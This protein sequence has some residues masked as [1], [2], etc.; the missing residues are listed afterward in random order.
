MYSAC[1]C[2]RTSFC[3][4][5]FLR[6][7]TIS[8]QLQIVLDQLVCG[9]TVKLIIFDS[10]NY[11]CKSTERQSLNENTRSYA[12]RHAI[13]HY[14]VIALNS[15]TGFFLSATRLYKEHFTKVY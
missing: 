6:T 11:I 8:A 3:V 10:L 9:R 14:N 7:V 12:R 13:N 2:A 5:R 4:E 15:V 1:V